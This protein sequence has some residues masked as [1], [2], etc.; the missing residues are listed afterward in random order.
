MRAIGRY[1]KPWDFDHLVA[2][3][4]SSPHHVATAELALS[5]PCHVWLHEASLVGVHLGLAHASGSESWARQ[6]V[7]DRL[8]ADETPATIALISVDELLDAPR[9]DEL[10]VTL[11]GET[12]DRARSV[13]V[14]SRQAAD[15]VRRLRPDGPPVLVLPL[16][17]GATVEPARTPARGDIVAVGW[18]AANKSPELA[19]DVLSRL[20]PDVTLTFVGPSAGDAADVVRAL[21]VAAGL[22]DRVSFTG[23]LDDD[24]YAERIAR[25]RVGLQLRTTNRGEMS[26]AITDL[27]AHGIPT[28]TTL[29]SA[30][31]T[32]PGLIV[33]D[34]TVDA[35]VAAISPLLD[36]DTW[37]VASADALAR[38]E[39]WT[40]DDVAPRLLAL[41]RRRRR[42]RAD[43]DPLPAVS[44]RR[45]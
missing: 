31:P 3:L 18:L 9:F 20:A 7:N 35:L 30:G 12:L 17:H 36:D 4:G 1:A 11:L 29:S 43:D 22:A 32:S 6:H 23:R 21:A 27:I 2:V 10:G 38:A 40:F 14:S 5:E 15:T 8:A 24:E 42:S 41:A 28:V 44:T 16:G 45:R 33:A 25:S 37:T 34:P 39:R 13:I 26:A 19:I